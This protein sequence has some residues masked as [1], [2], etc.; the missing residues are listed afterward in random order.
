[1]SSLMQE[2]IKDKLDNL[3]KE[4]SKIRHKE[5][6]RGGVHTS[7][8]IIPDGSWCPREEVLNYFKDGDD[9]KHLPVRVLRRMENGNA[10]HRK[11]QNIFE[12]TGVAKKIET[13]HFNKCYITGTPDGIIKLGNKKYVVEI[14][15]TKQEK[16]ESMTKL[17]VGTKRQIEYYLYLSGIPNGIVIYE[18]TNN[19][20]Y[21][22]YQV[23]FEPEFVRKYVERQ[24]VVKKWIESYP[25]DYK[26]PEKHERCT[27][28][29]A[30][31]ANS[32]GATELCFNPKKVKELV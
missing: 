8:L 3:F 25:E 24:Y 5:Q 4:H 11:W 14:K 15:S 30:G 1:M 29:S 26:L 2:M 7:S 13:Q 18:N 6:A 20:E 16:Y 31:R 28:K 21:Q 9:Y 22:I 17:P 32:C 23:Q 27:Y 19:S 12:K 10:V